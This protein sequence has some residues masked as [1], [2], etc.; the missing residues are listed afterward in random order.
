LGWKVEHVQLNGAATRMVAHRA[1]PIG[2][3]TALLMFPE[4]RLVIATMSNVSRAEGVAPFG[5]KVAEVF[6]QLR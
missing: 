5:V 6:A 4:R 3:T 2:G 1:T